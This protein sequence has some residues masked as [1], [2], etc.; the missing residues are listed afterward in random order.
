MDPRVWLSYVAAACGHAWQLD[1]RDTE[2]VL[3][4][5]EVL[6]V[7]PV[8]GVATVQVLLS[9][10]VGNLV[11]QRRGADVHIYIRALGRA[12][13]RLPHDGARPPGIRA[14][15]RASGISFAAA[16]PLSD[17]DRLAVDCEPRPSPPR[18]DRPCPR[19]VTA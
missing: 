3:R 11:V 17:Q 8:A 15:D 18:H 12:P 13:R 7:A 6:L 1:V 5:L 19:E 4:C 16:P 9:S 2:E 14:A 10:G